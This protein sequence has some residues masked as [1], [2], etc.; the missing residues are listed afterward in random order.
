MVIADEE[1]DE[2]A[3]NDGEQDEVMEEHDDD[4]NEVGYSDHD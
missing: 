4:D 3:W 1:D 2:L